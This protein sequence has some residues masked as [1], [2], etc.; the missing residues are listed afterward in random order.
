MYHVFS[1]RRILE[2]STAEKVSQVAESVFKG[3][4]FFQHF[5]DPTIMYRRITTYE[6]KS[7]CAFDVKLQIINME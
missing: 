7:E 1:V 3:L 5:C 4:D 2:D 6:L